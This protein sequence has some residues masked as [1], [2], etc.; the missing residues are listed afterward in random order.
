M[1][2]RPVEPPLEIELAEMIEMYE[3]Q[4]TDL[5]YKHGIEL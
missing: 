5:A 1:S 2:D 3:R 4:L